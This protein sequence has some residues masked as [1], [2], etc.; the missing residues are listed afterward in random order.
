MRG[1]LSFVT[2]ALQLG[3]DNWSKNSGA[4]SGKLGLDLFRQQWPAGADV[5]VIGSFMAC[6]VMTLADIENYIASLPSANH[7]IYDPSNPW[8][9]AVASLGGWAGA[10][11]SPHVIKTWGEP[12]TLSV[13]LQH[14]PLVYHVDDTIQ[15]TPNQVNV[16]WHKWSKGDPSKPQEWSGFMLPYFLSLYAKNMGDGFARPI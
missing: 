4:L 10:Y 5:Y 6:S 9:S 16:A 8:Q 15:D 12:V 13:G 14:A 2:G 11:S 1:S 3:D 7:F